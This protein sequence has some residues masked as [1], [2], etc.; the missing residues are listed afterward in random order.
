MPNLGNSNLQLFIF[1]HYSDIR[2]IGMSV[3]VN[4]SKFEYLELIKIP[5]F[6]SIINNAGVVQGGQKLILDGDARVN[7]KKRITFSK[8]HKF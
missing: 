7:D 5:S 3:F 6:F 8:I 4:Y 1:F 2:I